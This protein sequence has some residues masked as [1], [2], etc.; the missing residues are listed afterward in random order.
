MHVWQ[1]S[2]VVSPL[3]SELSA[4]EFIYSGKNFAFCIV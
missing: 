3:A 1:F 4:T 2:V